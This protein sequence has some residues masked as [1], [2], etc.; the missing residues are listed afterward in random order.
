MTDNENSNE[1]IKSIIIRKINLKCQHVTQIV[2]WEYNQSQ[3]SCAQTQN[4]IIVFD[5]PGIKLREYC[6]QMLNTSKTS[7][8]NNE[9][10]LKILESVLY[11]L[12]Y[13]NTVHH[14][15]S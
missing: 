1:L 9:Q 11:G 8:L 6:N 2:H 7:V 13:F 4:F 10:L 3:L 14:L 5:K 15:Y 12:K